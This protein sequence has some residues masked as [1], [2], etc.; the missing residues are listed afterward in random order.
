MHVPSD[1][2]ATPRFTGPR[3]FARLPYLPDADDADVMVFGMPWDGSTTFRSG[4][5]MGPEAIRSASALLRPYN[6]ALDVMVFGA[7]SAVDAGDA[8]TVPGYIEETMPRIEAFVA[9]ILARGAVPVGMGG[10]HSVTLAELRALHA[11]HGPVALVQFDAH[12]DLWD[13]YF[14]LPYNHGT[15]IRRAIEEGLVDPARSFTGGQR[16]SLYGPEDERI[17]ADLGMLL[18]P[19]RELRHWEPARLAAT[20]AERAGDAPVFLSFDIDFLEPGLAP[21]TGTPEAGGPRG[22]EALDCVRALRGLNLVGA[23]VVEVAPRYDGPGQATAVMA[24]NVLYEVL[25]LLALNRR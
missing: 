3:T 20:I 11:V 25:S 23:D 8:P 13:R 16:G 4:S 19:W 24:A 15:V 9:A 2:L 6:P 22:D 21:G 14:G 12:H 18:V 10:D 1:P 17:A 5:R 7:L